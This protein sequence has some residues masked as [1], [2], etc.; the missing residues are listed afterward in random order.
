MSF[1]I[2]TPTNQVRLTNVAIVRLKRKGKRFE[3]ACYKNK[4]MNWRNGIEK[5]LDEVLQIPSVFSNVSKGVLA[6]SKDLERV[7]KTTDQ[8]EVCKMI[9]EKGN[10]QVS[11]K[12]RVQ[13]F[14]NK[15]K[16]IATIV[17]GKCVNTQTK[18]PFPLRM[19]E[20]SM[21]EI[22]FTVKP[23]KSAKVQALSVIQQLKE[24][25]PIERAQMRL[26]VTLPEKHA[27]QI[28]KKMEDL[29]VEV[30]EEDW[31]VDCELIVRIDPGNYRAV[32]ERV[33]AETRGK[34]TLEIIDLQ[35]TAEGEA[36][37]DE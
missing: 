6:K 37:I 23:N 20:N 34:G 21:K 33:R 19:I 5:D 17:A 13:E 30:E 35:V 7:F 18:R 29:F 36:K 26:R 16:D 31:G 4:V 15:L 3:V 24:V 32:E 14:E 11:E 25:L 1:K 27:K 8:V 22:K 12:E 10:L 28:K 9:L 2:Q